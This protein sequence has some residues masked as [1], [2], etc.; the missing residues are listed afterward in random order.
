MTINKFDLDLSEE[1]VEGGILWAEGTSV[2]VD[3]SLVVEKKS[4]F[5][6]ST[7]LTFHS[8]RSHSNFKRDITYS[9]TLLFLSRLEINIFRPLR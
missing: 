1:F 6:I 9:S 4:E 3:S 2:E 5:V 7:F 8:Y